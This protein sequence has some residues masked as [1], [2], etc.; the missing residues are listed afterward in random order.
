MPDEI[1]A[2]SRFYADQ[3]GMIFHNVYDLVFLTLKGYIIF[4]NTRKDYSI[5]CAGL[6]DKEIAGYFHSI[7][8]DVLAEEARRSD[9]GTEK[10]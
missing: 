1:I 5:R 6:T 2:L 10:E 7:I 8:Y 9:V 3:Y 4:R